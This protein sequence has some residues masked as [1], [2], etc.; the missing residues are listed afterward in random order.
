[1]LCMTCAVSAV[2]DTLY[3]STTDLLQDLG[4]ILSMVGHQYSIEE[5]HQVIQVKIVCWSL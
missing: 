1:M 3:L 5:D 2:A 4:K